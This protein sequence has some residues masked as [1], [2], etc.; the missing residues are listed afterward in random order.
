MVGKFGGCM[1]ASNPE[2]TMKHRRELGEAFLKDLL[3]RG[4]DP[5][6]S[7]AETRVFAEQLSDGVT[8]EQ[9]EV[10]PPRSKRPFNPARPL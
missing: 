1:A 9:P 5:N 4:S 7:R 6:S 2:I 3:D 10:A 8:E